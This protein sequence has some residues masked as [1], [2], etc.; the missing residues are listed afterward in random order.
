M[1][2]LSLKGIVLLP[3]ILL[4]FFGV[5]ASRKSSYNA[6]EIEK[7]ITV[8]IANMSLEEKLGQLQ[9]Q[10]G[11]PW[12]DLPAT[13]V[14]F[15]LAKRGLIGS[16]FNIRGADKVNALQR[17]A[18]YSRQKI[19]LIFGFDVLH[20]YRTLF[21]IPLAGAASWDLDAVE[22]S[23]SIAAA[24]ARASG[25]SWTFGPMV[26]IARDPRWGR[27]ME[28]AGEDSV[29]GS[30]MARARVHGFQGNDYSRPDKVMACAKHFAGYG[31]AEAGRDYASVDMSE[32]QLREVY[33]PPFKAAIE[34][35][36]GS[37]MTAYMDL[38]GIPA[39]ANQW[40]L[41][42]VLRH[43]WG[44]DGMVVSDYFSISDM[45]NQ[46]L[47]ANDAEAAMYALNAGVDMEM[48]STIYFNNTPQLLK[49]GKVVMKTVDD[50]VRHVL[51]AKFRL[52]LFDD[53]YTDE[54]LANHTVLTADHLAI[55]RKIAAGT[56]V[57]LK[58]ENNILPLSKSIKRLAVIGS[59]ATNQT[60]TLDFW[61]AN[62]KAEDSVTIL[63]GIVDKIG[64]TSVK[65]APGC[66]VFCES[67]SGFTTAVDLARE[68]DM[69]V[70][71]VGE[72]KEY[73]GET[74]SRVDIGL[75][76]RQLDLVKAI[77]ATGKPYVVVLMTGRPLTI[78]WLAANAPAILVTWRAGTMGGPAVADV[79]FGDVNP[80]GKLPMTFP[81][82][83][84]QIPIHYDY[85][86]PGKP[87]PVKGVRTA[88]TSHYI[89][90]PNE[91]LYP[92]GVDVKNAGRREG[93]EV[94]Q[95]YVRDVAASVTR[96]VRQLKAFRKVLLAVAEGKQIDF[97]L[98][99][100]E[101]GFLD[102]NWQWTVEAGSL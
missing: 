94:V 41:R 2:I 11:N 64:P 80:S 30:E 23:A 12:E 58:N 45:T 56:F 75:T 50:A 100:K 69:V 48:V 24:E 22:L 4:A 74:A 21:P 88:F 67:A 44:F 101:L 9:Q 5:E 97:V 28:G 43:E 18:L 32:R 34:A 51:R 42:Q 7:K 91:P 73:S 39:S 19:P 87:Q 81:R 8:L 68:S 79:L 77:A 35:G 61:S 85:R 14:L 15:D 99:E 25:I 1:E 31:A 54:T 49:E 98:G 26:D 83:V 71:V 47:S 70:L 46:Q 95:L 76:G 78:E 55:A 38:N 40:L 16:V 62:A 63:Q 93:S 96:P 92:F 90:S 66:D 20:G 13:P 33:L 86:Q 36:I 82:S 65:F 84:G 17:A 3:V 72:P 57:L 6:A 59:L 10:A 60:Q 27:A 53:P 37:V 29:L 89:D 52:G 102:G